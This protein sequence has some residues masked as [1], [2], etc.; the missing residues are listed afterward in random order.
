MESNGKI[1]QNP[2]DIFMFIYRINH[3]QINTQ[4]GFRP[5]P[6]G[7]NR[8]NNLGL[9]AKFVGLSQ[10]KPCRTE[11]NTNPMIRLDIDMK[12]KPRIVN[13]NLNRLVV[14]V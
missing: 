14:T 13:R 1:S 4:T 8:R 2:K 3:A 12:I 11:T 9:D 6:L 10:T 5:G 7:L